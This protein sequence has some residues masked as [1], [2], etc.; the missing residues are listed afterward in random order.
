VIDK[1][2][3][4]IRHRREDFQ[5][6][7]GGGA[8]ARIVGGVLGL[9]LI[10]SL[11]LGWWWSGEPEIINMPEY[12]KQKAESMQLQPVTGYTTTATLIY[13]G[14]TLLDKPGGYISNDIFPPGLW[15]DNITNWEYGVLVQ[16]RDLARV[17]RKELSR[18]QSQSV[19]DHDLTIAEP[20]FH[21][22]NSS[23]A[24]PASESEYRRGLKA[25]H[26]YLSRLADPSQADA[27][28]Y[29]RSDNLRSW[30]SEVEN[31]LGSLSRRLSES[32]GR[33]QLDH[34][35]VGDAG[36]EQSTLTEGVQERKTPWLEIDDVFYEARG[37]TW[38]LVH[39]LKA[40]EHDFKSVLVNKNALVS[41]QQIIIELEATQDDIW[42]PMILNGG[43]FGFL[44]NHSLTMSSYISRATAAII[45]LRD[46]LQQG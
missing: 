17:F 31:R 36:A 46:L 16:V 12:A 19:E 22:D 18:S 11:A 44:A 13:L 23:W 2:A 39:I 15:L 43:G 21:F 38:A 30:L 5:D 35:L 24:L 3:D 45:D 41:L 9:Y 20:Q 25:A 7:L 34:G 28:F 29:A 37:T 40:I 8:L 32:V 1:I 26:R 42:S 10:L 27:Q 33:Q 4:F 6:Y 14:E